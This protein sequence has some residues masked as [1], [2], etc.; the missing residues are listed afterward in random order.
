MPVGP[1]VSFF[2]H[3]DLL[4]LVTD[5]LSQ[6]GQD[7][8]LLMSFLEDSLFSFILGLPNLSYLNQGLLKSSLSFSFFFKNSFLFYRTLPL[9]DPMLSDTLFRIC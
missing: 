4:L 5:H 2:S 9:P 1:T 8:G 7:S 6:P 3:V